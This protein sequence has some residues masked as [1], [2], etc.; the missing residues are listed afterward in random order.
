MMEGVLPEAWDL[1]LFKTMV[2][3]I[4]K[5]ADNIKTGKE[6][7]AFGGFVKV[8]TFGFRGRLSLCFLRILYITE[9]FYEISKLE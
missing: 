8:Y 7:S 9:A 1:I 2:L 5:T 3:Y 6:L 4:Y